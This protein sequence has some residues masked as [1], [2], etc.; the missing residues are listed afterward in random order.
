M[1]CEKCAEHKKRV[2]ELEEI[3]DKYDDLRQQLFDYVKYQRWKAQDKYSLI[4]T[5]ATSGPVD[6]I[7]KHFI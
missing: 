1:E 5:M 2:K 4:L 3:E 7:K 6:D